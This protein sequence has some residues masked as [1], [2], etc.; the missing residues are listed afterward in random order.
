MRRAASDPR[1]SKIQRL[2]QSLPA[3]LA[4]APRSRGSKAV[5]SGF[6]TLALAAGLR[7][8]AMKSSASVTSAI[9][10]S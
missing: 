4:R 7:R 8:A 9:I 1:R 5:T 6:P 10:R 3:A 2:G